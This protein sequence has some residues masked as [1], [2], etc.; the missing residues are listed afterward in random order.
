MVKATRDIGASVR[1]RLL[2]L[3][4]ERGQVLDLLLTRYALERLLYR[5]SLS[6]HRNRFVLKGAMLVTTWFEDPH[7]PT[8]DL[9][10]LGYGDP[11]TEAM[12]IVWK[13]I[14]GTVVDDGIRFDSEALRIAPIREELEYGGLRIRTTATMARAQIAVTIDIGFG[15]AVEPGVEEIDLPVLLD[16][17]VPRL[18]AY[19]RE[20]V[21]AE[22]FH[23]M[24]V[25]GLANSRLKDFYDV[26]VLSKHYTFD[27]RLAQAIAA[28]FRRRQTEIP[29]K[30]P[31]AFTP[32]FFR[33]QRK[34][35]QWSAF[36][37]DLSAEIPTL[38]TVVFEL[39]TFIGPYATEARA[40]VQPS[41][42][43][44]EQVP[45]EG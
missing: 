32:E 22:K 31:D 9:D 5:L 45:R 28:T 24:I 18:R 6:V 15:D 23:A 2:N 30:L 43:Q 10:L 26:W 21:I 13:E 1:A 33:N 35:Q 44:V 42:A 36:V 4:R 12:S 17:P 19:A 20:T 40:L 16:L 38:E 11:S 37:R 25:R 39:A 14:C 29:E 3:A 8:R 27:T 7:R 41:N 34:V